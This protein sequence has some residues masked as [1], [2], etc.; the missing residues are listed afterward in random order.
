MDMY[1]FMCVWVCV[2]MYV[3]MHVCMCMCEYIYIYIYI[4]ICVCYVHMNIYVYA[5]YMYVHTCIYTCKNSRVPG[6]YLVSVLIREKQHVITLRVLLT[7]SFRL[8]V[9]EVRNGFF[10][11]N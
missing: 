2:R 9:F 6:Q 10:L 11:C 8:H 4:Y 5:R 7:Y 3:C 1:V